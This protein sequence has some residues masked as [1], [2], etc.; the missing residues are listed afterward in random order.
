MSWFAT[1]FSIACSA[2]QPVSGH[3]TDVYGRRN[4]LLLSYAFFLA[5]TL[6]C[7]LAP[8]LS[9]FLLGR[10]LQGLG[11]GGITSI[12]AFL[13]TDLVPI[14]RRAFIE[15]LGNVAFGVTTALA[16][17][18][19]GSVNDTIG[20]RWAFLI[21]VPA[22]AIMAGIT[23]FVIKDPI[24]KI[25]LSGWRQ[26]DFVGGISLLAATVLLQLGLTTS[27]PTPV[28][29]VSL[30]TAGISFAIFVY[31]ELRVA[32]HPVIPIAAMADCT[33]ALSQ[34]SA[35]FASASY[36]GIIYYIPIYL[37]VTGNSS[38]K[39]G[40]RFIPLALAF[41]I[42]SFFSG[43]VVT[44]T[45][46]YYYVNLAIQAVEVLAGSLIC[47]LTANTPSFAP[48]IYLAL[49]G[50]GE[51]GACVTILMAL[52]SA[53]D[54]PNQTAVQAAV[55]SIKS[56]GSSLGVTAA[57]KLFQEIF[58]KALVNNLGSNSNTDISMSVIQN[59]TSTL[60]LPDDLSNQSIKSG[61]L[62]AYMTGLR[63]VFFLSLGVVVL[64]AGLSLGIKNNL[65]SSSEDDL[66]E[67]GSD[68]SDDTQSNTKSENV[69]QVSLSDDSSASIDFKADYGTKRRCLTGCF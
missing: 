37:Q 8:K 17:I 46:R 59:I 67:K 18:Y 26:I 4:G 40:L 53:T 23:A 38:S 64:A 51:G 61:V 13:E 47:T 16:G 36:A 63:A 66:S 52:L 34:L 68:E 54:G 44:A 10:I 41:G 1:T 31:W 2:T 3:L 6:I 55:W 49:L 48:F 50:L 30:P 5:G 9:V 20:W 65:L 45:A 35:F 62:D 24:Q 43:L 14:E 56:I 57:S 28:V 27:M 33:V 32:S 58:S 22:I 12:T 60:E 11:G 15:G 25:N 42:G 39:A 21:Q 29:C 7:G 19:G 69:E